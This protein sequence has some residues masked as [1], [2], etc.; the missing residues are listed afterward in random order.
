V[1][2]IYGSGPPNDQATGHANGRARFQGALVGLPQCRRGPVGLGREPADLLAGV[3][4]PDQ[5]ARL[6]LVA[7]G[8]D[9]VQRGSEAAPALWAGP[10]GSGCSSTVRCAQAR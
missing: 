2:R 8:L 4:Q 10:S 7:T 1:R 9:P 5:E 6:A 3:A